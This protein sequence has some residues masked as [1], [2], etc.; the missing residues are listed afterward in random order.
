MQCAKCGTENEKGR[1]CFNCGT[2]LKCMKCPNC[3]NPYL[4]DEEYCIKCGKKIASKVEDGQ[5]E[6]P[7]EKINIAETKTNVIVSKS[8]STLLWGIVICVLGYFLYTGSFFFFGHSLKPLVSTE[9]S[10]KADE[11]AKAYK[12]DVF[13]A[14]KKYKGKSMTINGIVIRKG[15]FNNSEDIYLDIFEDNRENLFVVVSVPLSGKAQANA[16]KVGDVI[17]VRGVCDGVVAQKNKD[18]T[19]VHISATKISY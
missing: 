14:D 10:L 13:G 1:F 9:Y 3:G 19:S 16:V 6:I 11:L 2:E 8:S 18:I 15:Q 7:D 12:Q 4:E 5:T 17:E